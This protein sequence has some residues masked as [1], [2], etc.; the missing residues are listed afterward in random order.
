MKWSVKIPLEPRGMGRPRLSTRA[1]H[2]RAYTAKKDR[3]WMNAAIVV[4]KAHWRR[5]PLEGPVKVRI[6]SMKSRPL[7]LQRRK[8]PEGA[9][10]AC[11]VPDADNVAKIILDSC[12][13][14]G[15]WRDDGQVCDLQIRTLYA[16]KGD[17]G[18]IVLEIE[19]IR[20]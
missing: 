8:D 10:W 12:T 11:G 18:S 15:I 9:M 5:P 19:A 2:A 13:Y 17:P 7:R 14:A 16:P 6:I 1:G 4:L 20:E 3:D